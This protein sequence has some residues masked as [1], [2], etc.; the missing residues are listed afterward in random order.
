MTFTVIIYKF[1]NKHAYKLGNKCINCATNMSSWATN[2]Y[3]LV[4]KHFQ[5]GMKLDET[6][7]SW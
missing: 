7:T 1:D 5:V 3:E 6:F 2:I 4:D